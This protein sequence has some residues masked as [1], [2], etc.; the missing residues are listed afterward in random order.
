[1]STAR[2]DEPSTRDRI[3]AA[4]LAGFADRGV[5][6]TSLD[7]VAAAVGVR[8]Q[9]LLYWFPSKELLLLAVV[10]H[11]VAELGER[12]TEAVLG[13][14]PDL[15]ERIVAVVDAVFRLGTTHPELFAVV[16]EVA[17]L[18]PPASTRLAAAAEPIVS[19]AAA[20]LGRE[21][22]GSGDTERIRRVLLA[23]GAQVVG[24]ATEAELRADLGL[25]ADLTWLRT[26][27]RALLAALRADLSE[28]GG[29]GR[30]G[31]GGRSPG[32]PARR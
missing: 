12:L 18:G 29:G 25:P 16:R 14:G 21:A 5:E 17:R 1:V 8:K 15:D 22:G 32:A 3:L 23:A 26:R 13:A 10:D 6:A 31:R 27:R 11:A 9:T 20:A 24:I 4:A 19:L 28:G 30:G 7:A 2:A